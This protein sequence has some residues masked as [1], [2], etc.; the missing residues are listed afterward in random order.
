MEVSMFYPGPVAILRE[1]LMAK[2]V[3]TQ[4]GQAGAAM[5]ALACMRVNGLR[6]SSRDQLA[7]AGRCV[8]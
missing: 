1:V 5:I 8:R 7:L 4:H 3:N 2:I 6:A